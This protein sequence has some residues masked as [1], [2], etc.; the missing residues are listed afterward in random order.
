[1]PNPLEGPD[2][3]RGDDATTS[4]PTP[5]PNTEAM[6]VAP[7]A[8]DLPHR[9]R[10]DVFNFYELVIARAVK[11]EEG[12]VI[13]PA[14]LRATTYAA[15][16]RDAIIAKKRFDW[17]ASFT[18]EELLAADLVVRQLD[19]SVSVGTRRSGRPKYG[20]EMGRTPM[21]EA[22]KSGVI[23][24]DRPI[25]WIQLESFCRLLSDRMIS[26]PIQLTSNVTTQQHEIERLEELF[27]VAFQPQ[28]N[29]GFLI[30]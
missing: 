27:D 15:R 8:Q 22:P 25:T 3:H 5:Q 1:M 14:P 7:V 17:P 30:L 6:Q 21:T 26:G 12:V 18:L 13:N 2:S 16:L 29:G 20:A 11:S 10:Q 9:F 4:S 19:Y 28:E 23:V 24:V